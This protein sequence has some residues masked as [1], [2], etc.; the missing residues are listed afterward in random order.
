MMFFKGDEPIEAFNARENESANAVLP[1]PEKDFYQATGVKPCDGFTL[2][3][4]YIKC[5]PDR[6][7]NNDYKYVVFQNGKLIFKDYAEND[8]DAYDDFIV[9]HFEINE[10]E[11]TIYITLSNRKAQLQ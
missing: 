9:N 8:N 10:A 6:H 4:F 1:E 5:F 11:K 7:E 2:F 3:W